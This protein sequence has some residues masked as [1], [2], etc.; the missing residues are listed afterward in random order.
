MQRRAGAGRYAGRRMDAAVSISV[1]AVACAVLLVVLALA[2][3]GAG[4]A[5]VRPVTG[6]LKV[7][8]GIADQ[9]ATAFDDK[10][11]QS[12][13][14]GYARRS[15]PWDA[16]RFPDQRDD[17]D[18]WV[19]GVRN[20]GAEPLITFA[21]S[22]DRAGHQHRPPGGTK[23]LREFNRFRNRYPSV[24]TYSA[25]N[26]ANQCGTGTCSR[27]DLVARYYNAIRR[28]CFGCKVVAA[29]LL[30]QPN[31]VS[32]VRAFRR[33][34]GFEPR[35][36]GLHDYIDANR[37]QTTRTTQLLRAVKGEVWL[38]EVGGLVARRNGSTVRLPQG[39]AHAAQAMRFIFDRL[40]RLSPRVARIYVY[41]WRSTTARDSWD[42]AL[43]GSDGARR[44]SLAVLERVVRRQQQ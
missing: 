9:K 10:R 43:V 21:R 5:G 12:L 41:H 27:P 7:K 38:T 42:S 29:D 26:E 13:G 19:Q 23:F 22:R 18:A 33:A 37:F 30:D 15:V 2:P 4:A 16:L 24:K 32:W 25:W 36:W 11:L 1:R 14:L 28:N 35:Y 39:K 20:M 3:S 31:M 17:L 34:A 44:P 6:P 8:V 40:A